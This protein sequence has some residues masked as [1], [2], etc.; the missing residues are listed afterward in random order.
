MSA[1][2]C[3]CM[4]VYVFVL[5]ACCTPSPEISSIIS[6][7]AYCKNLLDEVVMEIKN[8]FLAISVS[9]KIWAAKVV[10]PWLAPQNL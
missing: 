10:L 6:S 3:V 9:R 1:G 4:C 8:Y 5:T 7:S 2:I